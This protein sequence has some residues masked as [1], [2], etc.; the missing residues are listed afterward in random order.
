M[1]QMLKAWLLLLLL[2]LALSSCTKTDAL[3]EAVVSPTVTP[4]APPL[5]FE[6]PET[7]LPLAEPGPYE[8]SHIPGFTAYDEERADRKVT[9]SI[10]YPSKEG[11]PNFRG[12]PFPLII[13]DGKMLAKF[14]I[15]LASHG[16]IVAGISGIDTYSPWDENLF[17]Q[18]LDYVFTLDQLTDNPPPELVGLIDTDHV[19]V[20]GYSFGGRNS[21]V[22]SG[23]RLDPEYYFRNC[24]NP[25]TATIPYTGA[26]V[27]KMCAPYESWGTFVQE[28][29]PALTESEDGLW[30]AISDERIL[31][32]MPLSADSEWLFGPRGFASVDKA[33]L[34]TAGTNEGQRYDECFQIYEELGTTDK[35]FISFVEKGH[36][37]IFADEA[38]R[39]M[40]HLAIAFFSHH[41]KGYA[42]YE[43]Y[44]SEEFVS[45]VEDLAW[46]WYEE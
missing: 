24:E 2:S 44:F 1:T 4:T 31:A 42:A 41:L 30:Q 6:I 27:L 45:Q 22:L 35:I 39:I 8:I 38:P 46:G 20:W 34:L 40:Q 11:E 13:N 14:G 28:A 32:V 10:Y 36:G 3:T 18:P 19:G 9:V 5:A 15:H 43:F 21:V 16:F 26:S 25:D 7:G 17:N 29:G 23:A 33:V 12:A 37:M